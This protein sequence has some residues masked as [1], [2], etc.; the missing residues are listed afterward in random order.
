MVDLAS[1]PGAAV[2]LRGDPGRAIRVARQKDDRG[3]VSRFG[4]EVDLRHL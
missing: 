4:A 2:E 3:V 1:G